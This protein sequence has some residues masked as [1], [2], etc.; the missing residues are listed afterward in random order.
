V[1]FPGPVVL[2]G[3]KKDPTLYLHFYNHLPLKRTWSLICT[4]WNSLL[5][6]RRRYL[7]IFFQ[8]NT[9]K[10]GFPYCGLVWPLRTLIFTNLNLHYF[11]KRLCKSEL[12]RLCGSWEENF[13]MTPH[14]F[15][16]FVIISPL[17]RTWSLICTNWNSLYVR[18]ICKK[19]DWNWP[20]SSGE[21]F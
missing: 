17:K 11:R 16:I 19:F 1:S 2:Q 20:T 15:C 5:F 4:N 3:K 13:S 6:W 7:K 21:D 12:F 10:N 14:Y 9:C 18:M 8:Y